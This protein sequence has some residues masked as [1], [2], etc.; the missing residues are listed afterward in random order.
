MSETIR[1]LQP[2]IKYEIEVR[3][4]GRVELHVPFALGARLIIFVIQED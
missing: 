4:P 2:V 1:T 3:E